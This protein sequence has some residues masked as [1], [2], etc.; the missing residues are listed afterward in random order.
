MR[1]LYQ[2]LESTMTN[3]NVIQPILDNTVTITDSIADRFTSRVA[4]RIV[5]HMTNRIS[6]AYRIGHALWVSD[7]S[8]P[9]STLQRTLDAY[10]NADI[11]DL[12]KNVSESFVDGI[13]YTIIPYSSSEIKPSE[14]IAY[15]SGFAPDPPE[16]I[17]FEHIAPPQ[18]IS[19]KLF[20]PL[21]RTEEILSKLEDP[22]TG[23]NTQLLTYMDMYSLTMF[24][25]LNIPSSSV[26]RVVA[27]EVAHITSEFVWIPVPADTELNADTRKGGINVGIDGPQSDAASPLIDAVIR[28]IHNTVISEDMLFDKTRRSCSRAIARDMLNWTKRHWVDVSPDNAYEE[29]ERACGKIFATWCEQIARPQT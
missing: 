21:H 20:F 29:C 14:S 2:A 4:S 11:D 8:D 28:Y 26:T 10:E 23:S 25:R 19:P 5:T 15:K 1:N 9:K 16:R 6:G 7:G 17:L 24:I 22:S 18:N 27:I 12:L 3:S 13:E